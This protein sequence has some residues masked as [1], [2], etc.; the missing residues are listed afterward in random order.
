MTIKDIAGIDF[1]SAHS[2]LNGY[3]D[4]LAGRPELPGQEYD[5]AEYRKGY[6]VGERD[7]DARR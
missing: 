1:R 3:S 4:G 5:P 7:R 6:Y 2:W